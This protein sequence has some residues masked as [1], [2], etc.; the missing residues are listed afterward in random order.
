M[1]ITVK[2]NF[3]RRINGFSCT[4][5]NKCLFKKKLENGISIIIIIIKQRLL[6]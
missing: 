6:N 4:K 3:V 1:S 5:Y 2:L